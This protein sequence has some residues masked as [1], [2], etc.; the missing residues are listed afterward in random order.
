MPGPTPCVLLVDR[1]WVIR[2]SLVQGLREKGY[3]VAEASD[4]QGTLEKVGQAD[5]AVVDRDLPDGDGARLAAALK[6]GGSL[7]AVILTT[8]DRT[9]EIERRAADDGLD[10]VVEKPFLLDEILTLIRGKLADS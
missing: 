7:R 9:E 3:A 1:E 5:V 10:A 6:L 2:W 4:V 8:T